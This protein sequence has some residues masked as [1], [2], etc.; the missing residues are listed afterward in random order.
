[1]ISNA[2]VA[3]RTTAPIAV[4]TAFAT[5][6]QTTTDSTGRTFTTT[7][8]QPVPSPLTSGF[9]GTGSSATGTQQPRSNAFI[10]IIVGV[11]AGVGL[12][13]ALVIFAIRRR[14]RVAVA[15]SE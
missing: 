8:I 3:G 14:R 6:V 2:G 15:A 11:L 1:M 9:T 12:L 4:S 7:L 13:I 5:Q 10:G